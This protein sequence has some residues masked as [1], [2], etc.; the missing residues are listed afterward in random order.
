MT[1]VFVD[2]SALIA[3]GNT[4]DAFHQTATAFLAM[5]EKAVTIVKR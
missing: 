1:P 3:I 4:R 2:T 5:M